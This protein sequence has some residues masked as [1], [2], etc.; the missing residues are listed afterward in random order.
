MSLD[1]GET[2]YEKCDTSGVFLTIKYKNHHRC[3]LTLIKQSK[4][5][6]CGNSL[7]HGGRGK[8][9]VHFTYPRPYP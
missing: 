6:I 4:E 2:K 3:S 7:P 8:V 9:C 1:K 5:F